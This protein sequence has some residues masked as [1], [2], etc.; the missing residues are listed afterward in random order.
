MKL[1]IAVE[2]I[3]REKR[4][5]WSISAEGYGP[6]RDGHAATYTEAIAAAAKEGATKIPV[7]EEHA[8]DVNY[9]NGQRQFCACGAWRESGGSWIEPRPITLGEWLMRGNELHL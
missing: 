5:Q 2:R 3:Q 7:L 4:W 8:H 9:G 1:L 6:I